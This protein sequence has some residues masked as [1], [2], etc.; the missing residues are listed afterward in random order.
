M[1]FTKKNNDLQ[2]SSVSVR[3]VPDGADS[4]LGWVSFVIF[5]AVKLNNIAIR[6]GRDGNIFLTYPRKRYENGTTLQ[7]F[8]PVSTEASQ[9]IQEAIQGRLAILAKAAAE[10]GTPAT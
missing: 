2:I 10:D 9:M 3:S 8:H 5:G 6:R 4:L 7:Y 1:R